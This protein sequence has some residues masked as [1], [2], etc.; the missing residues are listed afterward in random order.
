MLR[1]VLHMPNIIWL[2][3]NY[4]IIDQRNCWQYFGERYLKFKISCFISKNILPEVVPK[5]QVSLLTCPSNVHPAYPK[6]H[7]RIMRTMN[8]LSQ[9]YINQKFQKFICVSVCH[10]H[11]ASFMRFLFITFKNDEWCHFVVRIGSPIE[12]PKWSFEEWN[13]ST[14][15]N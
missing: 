12:S 6:I 5:Y 4:I 15:S 3:L 7:I 9:L 11:R 8:P 14:F 13:A 2:N 10:C 1:L